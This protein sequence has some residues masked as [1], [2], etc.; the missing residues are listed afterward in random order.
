MR[1]RRHHLARSV[2]HQVLPALMVALL[3]LRC[4]S[5]SNKGHTV[6]LRILLRL[7]PMVLHPVQLGRR[8]PHNHKDRRGDLKEHPRA[9]RLHLGSKGGLLLQ[10]I[11]SRILNESASL[12]YLLRLFSLLAAPGDRSHIPDASRPA[13]TIISEQLGRLRQTIPVRILCLLCT[14]MADPNLPVKPQQK[15]IVDDLDRRINP[16]FDALNCETLSKSV[17]DQLL[18]L[19]RGQWI[20]YQ[21][22]S[23]L[24]VD[25]FLSNT[26]IEAH[27]RDSA[28][29]IHVDLLTK[30]SQTDDIGLWMSGLKQLIL[31]L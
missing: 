6:G 29:A 9:R 30:G 16:L 26:A 24:I 7:D 1:R 3:H 14:E 31:R 17:V 15:R 21:I 23:L 18:V 19:T 2:G 13:Y 4:P 25:L 27:D 22:C 8:L 11:V 28:L 5:N 12:I 20:L 10:N